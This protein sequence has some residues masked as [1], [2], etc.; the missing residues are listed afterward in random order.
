MGLLVNP[1][2]ATVLFITECTLIPHE[3]LEVSWITSECDLMQWQSSS[4]PQHWKVPQEWFSSMWLVER[5]GEDSQESI[6]RSHNY[7]NKVLSL[8]HY[9]HHH[10][11]LEILRFCVRL[12]SKRIVSCLKKFWEAKWEVLYPASFWSGGAGKVTTIKSKLNTCTHHVC[13]PLISA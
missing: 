3:E 4:L 7:Q 13:F 8:L 10:Q 2:F 5:F 1:E 12:H 6:H 11:D 9:Q